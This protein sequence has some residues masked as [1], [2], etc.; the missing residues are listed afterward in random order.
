[1]PSELTLYTSDKHWMADLEAWT[2]DSR[3]YRSIGT[4]VTVYHQERTTSIWGGKQADWEEEPAVLIRIRNVYSGAGPAVAT[5]ERE[6][7]NATRAE[8]KECSTGGAIRLREDGITSKEVTAVLDVHKV[9]GT[10]TIVIGHETLTG[11][12]SASRIAS[13]RA[14][15]AAA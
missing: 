8:L 1:M 11:V 6:W 7:Q 13:E 14:V 12:V 10:V 4:H 9:E 15:S 5:R 2:N 3:L